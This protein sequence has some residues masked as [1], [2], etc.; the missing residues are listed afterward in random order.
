MTRTR[1]IGLILFLAFPL[2]VVWIE[3]CTDIDLHLA[4]AAFDPQLRIFPWRDAWIADTF[5]HVVLKRILITL[6]IA[7]VLTALWDLVAPRRWSWLQRYRIR[8]VALSAVMVPLIIS[9]LKQSSDSHCPWNLTRYGGSEPYVRLMQ[10]L[11]AGSEP[12]HCMPAGHASSALWL[13]SI[14]VFFLPARPTAS[15]CTF[16]TMMGFG[17][18][19]GWLQQLRGAHFLTHTLWSLWIATFVVGVIAIV[20]DRRRSPI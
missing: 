14:T 9:L 5:S 6:A 10:M 4:D 16:I 1:W 8:V 13:I 15:M 7:F 19:L 12:G 3:M 11:P 20:L 18:S 17:F 2:L